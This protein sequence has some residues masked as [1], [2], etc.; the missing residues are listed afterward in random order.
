MSDSQDFISGKKMAEYLRKIADVLETLDK[1]FT[2]K[3]T[4]K[5]GEKPCE[6]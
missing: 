1:G 2:A 3:I 6:R 5:I 4:F